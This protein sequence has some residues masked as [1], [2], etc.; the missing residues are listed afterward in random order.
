MST[1]SLIGSW[2]LLRAEYRHGET[3]AH[4][5]GQE[6]VGL[7][8]YDALGNMTVQIMHR[9]YTLRRAGQKDSE[10]GRAAFEGY[11]GYFGRYEIREAEN[12]V[13]H[14]V[15]GSTLPHWVGSRQSRVYEFSENLLRLSSPATNDQ[16][17]ALAVLVWERLSGP[18][19]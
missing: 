18:V 6:P 19:I 8:V 9:D 4:P 10:S 7:L 1:H 5:F 3:V 15:A 12:T 16:Q 14:D 17:G 13:V 2:K 11:L